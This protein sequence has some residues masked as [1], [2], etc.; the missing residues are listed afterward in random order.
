MVH[1]S[2]SANRNFHATRAHSI[3]GHTIA[4]MQFV[5]FDLFKDFPTQ[6]LIIPNGGDAVLYHGG[7][8]RGLAQDLERAPLSDLMSNV[9]FDTCLFDRLDAL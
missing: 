2:A 5:T 9:Y 8:Y 6:R 3:N 7:R 4:F 1:V